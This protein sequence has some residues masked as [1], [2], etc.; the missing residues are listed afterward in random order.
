MAMKT[1]KMNIKPIAV[2]YWAIR[3]SCTLTCEK[4]WMAWKPLM[5]ILTC[6]WNFLQRAIPTLQLLPAWHTLNVQY[7]LYCSLILPP[8]FWCISKK[9]EKNSLEILVFPLY[10]QF[11][12]ILGGWVGSKSK[13]GKMVWGLLEQKQK[14]TGL[15]LLTETALGNKHYLLTSKYRALWWDRMEENVSSRFCSYY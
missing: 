1:Q 14:G 12:G 2:I 8:C 15:L 5:M 4:K 11:S 3:T 6:I 13:Q 9:E 7:V 10:R